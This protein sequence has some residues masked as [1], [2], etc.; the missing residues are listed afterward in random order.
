MAKETRLQI[1][2]SE[3]AYNALKA[4]SDASG[5]ASA[6]LVSHII[7]NSLDDI[8]RLTDV[9]YNT[10]FYSSMSV[11]GLIKSIRRQQSESDEGD[12]SETT[13][14]KLAK[15][16]DLDLDRLSVA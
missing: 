8:D 4:F 7:E 14:I 11:E 2:F 15:L 3:R 10:N 9:F 12:D 16:D 1:T 5:M 13:H 6:S